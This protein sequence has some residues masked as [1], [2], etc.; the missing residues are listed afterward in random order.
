VLASTIPQS[1]RLPPWPATTCY[2]VAIGV[3]IL[4]YFFDQSTCLW[5]AMTGLSCPGCGMIHAFLALGHGNVRAAWSFNPGSF[6]VLPILLWAGIR[7]VKER[8]E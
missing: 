6:V 2:L 5:H 3:L 7:R 1:L 8:V 4:G